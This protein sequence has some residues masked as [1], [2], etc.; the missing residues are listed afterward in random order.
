MTTRR[1]LAE[2]HAFGRRRLVTAL[3]SGAADGGEPEP[4]RPGRAMAGGAAL[5][6]LLLAGA[7]VSGVLTGRT[8]IDWHSPVLVIS[9]QQGRPPVIG[10]ESKLCPAPGSPASAPRT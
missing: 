4:P 2:A 7:V 5:G 8:E 6:A 1:A 9:E 10:R 3:V